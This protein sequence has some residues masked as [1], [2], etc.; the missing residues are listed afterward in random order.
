MPSK[1]S[2]SKSFLRVVALSAGAGAIV[3]A[4]WS[5][6]H[7]GSGGSPISNLHVAIAKL[8]HT[9]FSLASVIAL[10]LFLAFSFYWDAAAANAA[11]A[12]TSESRGSRGIHLFLVTV[13][14]I[15]LLFPI[16]YLR[17]RFFPSSEVLPA[18]GR[19]LEAGFLLLAIW[20]RRSL[21][22]NWS[23]I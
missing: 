7:P 16:P 15:L 2:K 9:G 10:L 11:K 21:G 23:A 5:K 1:P 20:A 14:Q 22:Q 6:L 17:M 19:V 12:Q 4:L 18:I 8:Q 3:G 13:A